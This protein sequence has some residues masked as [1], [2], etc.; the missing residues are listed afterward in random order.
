MN[1]IL[2]EKVHNLGD[3]GEQVNVK[4]G[5]GRNF[6]I[7]QGKAVSATTD[8][9]AKF[10]ARRAELEKTAAEKLAAAETRKAALVE[11]EVIITQKAGDE[12]KLFGSVG[13]SDIAQAITAA[14]AEVNKSE[15]RLPEGALRHVGEFEID[16]E[17]HSDAV[18]TVKLSIVAE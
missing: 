16:V 12:G 11:L 17:L 15:V 7:P 1:V 14:G 13:T 8:N 10:E 2:L 5:Y 18:A 3:L 9:I 6:L 4:A